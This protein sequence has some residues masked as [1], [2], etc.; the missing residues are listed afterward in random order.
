MAEGWLRALGG[1]R[2]ESLSAG[3]E[4]SGYV[5]PL[6]IRVM[7]EAGVDISGQRSKSIEEFLVDPPD[8]VVSVCENASRSCPV[9]PGRVE[10]LLWPFDDPAHAGGSEDEKLA[11]FR[12]VRDEI[13]GRIE[14]EIETLLARAGRSP[15]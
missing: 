2:I 5:H 14:S 1:D 15:G 7:R 11:F 3:S 8:L 4:P 10:R 9:F 13:R 6:A 12:R